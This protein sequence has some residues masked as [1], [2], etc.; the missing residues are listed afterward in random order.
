LCIRV[1]GDLVAVVETDAILVHGNFRIELGEIETQLLKHPVVKETVVL[2]RDGDNSE[3]Y[4]CAYLVTR[5]GKPLETQAL[6]EFLSRTLPAYMIPAH[7]VFLAQMPLNAN[8]KIDRQALPKPGVTL[9][10]PY[11][12]PGDDIEARLVE[13]WMH[14]LN[15]ADKEGE[16]PLIGIDDH[17]FEIG[18]HSLNAT[19][20]IHQIHQEFAVDIPLKKVFSHPTIKQIAQMIRQTAKNTYAPIPAREECEYYDLSYAQRR[21]WVLC[22]FEEDS[23]A[24]NMPGALTLNG[25]F[26]VGIFR[27]AIQSLIDRHES[28]RT[29]F[30]I[31]DGIPRQRIV[32]NIPF[33]MEETDLHSLDERQKEEQVRSIFLQVADRP[34]DLEHG[35]LLAAR[36]IRLDEEK[37][38]LIWNTHHIIS[39]GWSQGVITNDIIRFYNAFQ[40]GDDNPLPALKIQY[41]DYT[42]WHNHL[43][44]NHQFSTEQHYWLDKFKDKPT[45]IDLPLDFP[46]QSIQTFNGSRVH[47][48]VDSEQTSILRELTLQLDATLFMGL[49]TLLS[50]FL[51]RTSGQRDIILGAPIANR[52]QV[53]LQSLVGFFVNTLVYRI[54]VDPGKSFLGQLTEVKEEA[55]RCYE[56]QDYPFDL[57][58]EE[59]GLERDLSQ[60]PLFN[61][62]I[63]YNNTDTRDESLAMTG[64]TL[65][66][67]PYADDFNMSKFDLIFFMDEQKDEVYIRIEYN[68]DLFLRSRIERLVAQFRQFIL[69]SL[70]NYRTP[71]GLLTT[72]TDREYRQVVH[73]FN[74]HPVDFSPVT[75]QEMFEAQVERTPD[76]IAVIG[77][78]LPGIT[79]RELNGRANRLAHYL[80]RDHNT[81][82]NDIIGVSMDRSIDM[83]VV[84]LGIVKSGAA[85][86]A[87]DPTYPRERVLHVLQDSQIALLIIDKMRPALFSG[88]S[89]TVIDIHDRAAAIAEQP[90]DN[91][92]ALNQPTDILYVNYTSG[93]TG[94]PNGAMLSHDCLTNLIQWQNE[95]SGVDCSR[96]VLQFTSINFCVSFQ[97]IMGT[98]TSGG[99]LHLIGEIERQETDYLLDF[100]AA[101]AIEVLFLPFSYL[102]FLFNETSR[103]DKDFQYHLQHI[104]TAGEQLKVTAGLKRFLDKNPHIKLHNHYG[105]T[106][107]HVV[108]SY[109]LDAATAAKTPIPPAGKPVSNVRIFILDE[110]LQVVPV[111]VWGEL[112]VEG[113]EEIAG[114]INNREL[115][116][117][118]LIRQESLSGKRLYRSGDIGRWL[119]D[120]NIEL[121]GRK[122]FMVKV[123]GFRVELGEIESRVLGVKGVREC[124]V[125]V[126]EDSKGIKTLVAYVSLDGVEVSGVR[127]AISGVLP[128][129]M[130]PRFV[131]VDGLPLMP[132]G[133]VDRQALSGM[134]LELETLA[135]IAPEDEFEWGLAEIWAEILNLDKDKISTNREFFEIG[136][137][138]LKATQMIVQIHKRFGVEIPL[139]DILRTSPTIKDIAS[140]LRVI[141]MLGKQPDEE[142]P[143]AQEIFI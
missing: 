130:V 36:L 53:E 134:R 82:G 106:E 115:T 125:V 81:R 94:T 6:R 122:D 93:S 138:S 40:R 35:P 37:Y 7:F 66:P 126:K 141:Q 117:K 50:T 110:N 64:V 11:T 21:L 133:K 57:L 124:V 39:D 120:G 86:L 121:R 62:M 26:D 23:T 96:K 34:F 15:L 111:G 103:W 105:S 61:V 76:Q 38:L 102:N 56:Y 136:G 65:S 59:L 132:N 41:K 67:Y 30:V 52:K 143:V 12:P 28:L 107:M 1:G 90:E 123:R 44:L 91:P 60:S 101:H 48:V 72:I 87:V 79:Y 8:G 100:L 27:H 139:I 140:S 135:Y 70:R 20:M 118:K 97:E 89:G 31:V 84:L 43:I 5:A 131:V 54:P 22:Q 128:Q 98:L 112:C 69:E 14:V 108:T 114:Y 119:A 4:L 104:V 83:I 73:E 42:L 95:K 92:P 129:Y 109:T 55:L 16:P 3:K 63:A 77:N 45:G 17:F 116:E 33:S 80:R 99:E 47:F 46:R 75:I 18:G 78:T 85:Y 142:K 51:Y 137:H 9:A 68:S 29:I 2:A 88:Y 32:K 127:R 25:T 74:D 10:R 19:Q 49:L 24:Y 71:I 13:T 58:V 113:R